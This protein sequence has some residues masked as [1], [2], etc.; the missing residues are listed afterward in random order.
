MPENADLFATAD[1]A[2]TLS[3]IERRK[4]AKMCAIKRA[5]RELF[6]EKGFKSTTTREIAERADVGTGTVFLYTTSK[7]ELLVEIF[8]EELGDTLDGAF[9]RI[10]ERQPLLEQLLQIFCALV[11]YHDGDRELAR[12]FVKELLFV[13]H[14][15]ALRTAAFLESLYVRMAAMIARAQELGEFPADVPAF[16]LARNLFALY[17]FTLKRWLGGSH[18]RQDCEAWLRD[19]LGL[20]LRCARSETVVRSSAAAG[21]SHRRRNGKERKTRPE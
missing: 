21:T 7:E 16:A 5:A 14:R 4:R 6:A 17:V 3:R 9:A 15:L 13:E 8:I 1:G 20:H 18:R 11:R 10:D 19:S 12:V 2:S